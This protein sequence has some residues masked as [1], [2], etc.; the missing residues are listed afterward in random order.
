MNTELLASYIHSMQ[1]I[2]I[3]CDTFGAIERQINYL[4]SNVM[5]H[6]LYGCIQSQHKDSFP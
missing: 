2:L 3:L 6:K 5:Y 1:L 4:K